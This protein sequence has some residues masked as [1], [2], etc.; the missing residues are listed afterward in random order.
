MVGH[1]RVTLAFSNVQKDQADKLYQQQH[2]PNSPNYHQW[3][4]PAEYAARF[5]AGSLDVNTVSSYLKDNGATNLKVAATG[6]FVSAD[7][8][9]P[10]AERAFRTQFGT[11][12]RPA[13]LVAEGE[14]GTFYAPTTTPM[15]PD[16]VA[17]KVQAVFGL[18]DLLLQHPA[19]GFSPMMM[20]QA[21]QGFSGYTPAQLA[22]AYDRATLSGSTILGKG[23]RIAIYSPTLRYTGDVGAFQS[24]FGLTGAKVYDLLV[25]GGPTNG[26]GYVEASLDFETIVGQAPNSIIIGLEPPNNSAYVLDGYD[27]AI[28]LGGIHVISSSWGFEEVAL[29]ASGSAGIALA[30]SFNSEA[31]ALT[32]NGITVFEAAGDS[33]AFSRSTNF[34]GKLTT[35]MEASSPYC[36]GVGGTRLLLN[37]NN[38]YSSETAW[39]YVA[40]SNSG[41]GG[42]LSQIFA[43]PTWQVGPGVTNSYSN[44]KR[45]VPDVAADADPATGFF[46]IANYPNAGVVGGTSAATP[47]W[48]AHLLLLEQVYGIKQA[49]PVF[50]GNINPGLYQLG[51][52]FENPA[53]VFAGATYCFHD[54]KTGSDGKYPATAA[55]DFCTGWGSADYNHLL[56]DFAYYSKFAGYTPDWLPYTPGSTAAG[57]WTHPLMIHASSTSVTEP[58]SFSHLSTYYIGIAAL[59]QGTADA[60]LCS[61]VI[62]IDGVAHTFTYPALP[63][64]YYGYLTNVLA[65]IKLTVGTH[66]LVFTLNNGNLLRETSTANDTYTRVITV[67]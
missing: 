15:L 18:S 1:L 30:N 57:T 20:G 56:A 27:A 37:T 33:G 23:M 9:V 44:G 26:N 19:A 13:K 36:S 25:D 29:V 7:M 53:G 43:R 38:T 32:M 40:A 51:A 63:H 65:G 12:V 34:K 35:T 6:L 24:Q 67:I 50:L 42:G 54:I 41:G 55:W 46:V 5:G 58:S 60:P 11:F 8:S 10:G 17:E 4:S 62:K 52:W 21:P 28:Q 39:T 48:A 2:D 64:G 14:P 3:I 47:L 31:Q 59:N 66:T 22:T 49:K 45:Q 61:S 16:Y